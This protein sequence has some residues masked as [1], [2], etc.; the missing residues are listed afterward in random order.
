MYKAKLMGIEN[1]Q[2]CFQLYEITKNGNEDFNEPLF[3]GIHIIKVPLDLFKDDFDLDGTISFEANN[4]E[5]FGSSGFLTK[6][7]EMKN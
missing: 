1:D 7:K 4:V 5:N 2:T 6:F 3:E